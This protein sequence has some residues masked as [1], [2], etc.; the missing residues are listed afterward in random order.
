[1]KFS[2]PFTH[3]L[4]GLVL[5]LLACCATGLVHAEAERFV[6]SADGKEV[7]DTQTKLVWQ[8]CTYGQQWDGKTC[9]GKAVKV[10]LQK[11]RQLA[12]ENAPWHVPS[13]AELTSLV[14]TTQKKKPAIDKATFP[15]TQPTM[16]WAL[17]LE[18][19]DNLNAWLVDFSKG[20]V[21]GNSYDSKQL[22][23]LVRAS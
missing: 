5:A 4:R 21:F 7:T 14:D 13:K 16:Y 2:G 10:T 17:R 1:M 12:T 19:N 20:H 15:G 6:I 18:M 3:S 23:R 8:R 11:A 9:A 22:L